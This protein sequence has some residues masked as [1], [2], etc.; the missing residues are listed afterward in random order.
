MM[1]HLKRLQQTYGQIDLLINKDYPA[2]V[3]DID[4]KLLYGQIV[5]NVLDGKD[6][7]VFSYDSLVTRE[8]QEYSERLPFITHRSPALEF[9]LVSQTMPQ[10]VAKIKTNKSALVGEKSK[11]VSTHVAVAQ[12]TEL[13]N[14]INIKNLTYPTATLKYDNFLINLGYS[15]YIMR[16]AIDGEWAW[17]LVFLTSPDGREVCGTNIIVTGNAKLRKLS[18]Y[19]LG[20]FLLVDW[21]HTHGFSLV[22]FS[23]FFEY[24]KIFGQSPV[25]YPTV[26]VEDVTKENGF[27]LLMGVV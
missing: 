2:Y 14:I 24:K 4:G 9:D 5:P 16:G 1:T 27:H 20:H 11:R 23:A 26:E 7:F 22:R 21:A 6:V 15:R 18:P 19:V 10:I 17:D 3:I 8:L 13:D 12:Q 25:M